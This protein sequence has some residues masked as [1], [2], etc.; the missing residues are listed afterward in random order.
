MG[1]VTPLRPGGS[2]RRALFTDA[3]GAG[4]RVTWHA[5]RDLVVLSLWREDR[6]VGTFRMPVAEAGRLATFLVDHLARE[7]AAA[8]E[9]APLAATEGPGSAPSSA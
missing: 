8:R 3:R 6:C 5:E 7:A 2:P 1:G 4:L 9:T